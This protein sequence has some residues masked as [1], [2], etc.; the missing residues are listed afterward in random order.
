MAA[1]WFT[2]LLPIL[3]GAV[4]IGFFNI[5]KRFIMQ[6][7]AVT[8]LQ[9]LVLSFLATTVVFA[10]LYYVLWGL[11]MP[12]LLPG[13]WTAVFGTTVAN[14]FIQFFNAKAASINE[15]E[16]SL[17]APLQAMTPGLIT[18]LA[19]ILGEYPSNIGMAGITLMA[20]GSYILLFR[21]TPEKWYHYFNPLRRLLLLLKLRNL[22]QEER[23]ATIVVSLALASACMGTVGLIFDGLFTRR[24][25][26]M[27][28]LT[29]GAM[30]EVGSLTLAYLMWYAY[31]P[32]A[33]KINHPEEKTIYPISA[34]ITIGLITLVGILW[35]THIFFV[36]PTYNNTLVAYVGT[37]KRLQILVSVALGFLF[38]K[39]KDFK[40]R[41]F[42]AVLIVAGAILISMDD[43]PGRVSTEV[44]KWGF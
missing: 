13:F 17:T 4:V 24:G 26:T 1:F 3:G 28:G 12:L 40:K 8:P 44:Q 7:T 27:Q 21:K 6:R 25:V 10:L 18:A 42:A 5:A 16:V 41:F 9:F 34:Y 2:V 32:D 22:S 36:N 11:T 31:K 43:L 20:L 37:L 39:E 14:I 30:I 23:G 38:F 35:V 15:G 33:K 29:L 19:V